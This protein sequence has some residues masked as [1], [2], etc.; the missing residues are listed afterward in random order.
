ML[1]EERME[2]RQP[3]VLGFRLTVSLVMVAAVI[4]MALTT[5]GIVIVIGAGAARQ[6]ATTLF[7][8]VG[9]AVGDQLE[10]LLAVPLAHLEYAATEPDA[11]ARFEGSGVFHPFFPFL[12]GALRSSPSLRSLTLADDQGLLQVIRGTDPEVAAHYRAPQGTRFIVRIASAAGQT[13]S[14]IHNGRDIIEQ[15]WEP[16]SIAVTNREWFRLARAARGIGSSDG[17]AAEAPNKP[18]FTLARAYRGGR[19]LS[20]EIGWEKLQ[21][22]LAAQAT[23]GQARVRLE[24]RGG[25]IAESPGFEM[26]KDWPGQFQ[27][28]NTAGQSFR[29]LVTAPPEVFNRDFVMLELAVASAT[30]ILLLVL[31]PLTMVFTRRLTR[32]VEK[33]S[34][35][36]DRVWQMDFSGEAPTSSRIREFDQLAHGFG[37]M[38]LKLQSETKVLAEA[39]LKLKKIVETGIALSTEKDSN[40][41]C[42]KILDTA[43][44]LTDADGGTLYLLDGTERRLDFNIMLNDTLGTRMGGTSA[45][46]V[47]P[48]LKVKLYKDDGEE[49]HNNVASHAF[50]TG[51]TIN[52]ADAY[53]DDRFD[54][55]GTRAFDENNKYRSMSFLTVPLKPMGGDVLGALQLIN[56]KG[57][58]GA[59]VP[60]TDD[61]QDFVEAL[62]AS[63]A[64]AI[65]NKQLLDDLEQLFDAIIDIINGAIGRKSPYT[66]GHCERVPIIATALA[67]ATSDVRSGPLAGFRLNT[68]ELRE[69]VLAAKLHDV[70]KVTTPEYVVDKS[71]KLETIYNRIHEIRTRFEV[72][73]RDAVIARHEAVMSK[74]KTAAAAD[75]ELAAFKAVLDEEWAFIAT[76][77]LGGEF[78]DPA[79][80]EKVKAIG[81]RT[82]LRYF[83]DR[84]GLS[85]EEEFRLAQV[86][87][88]GKAKPV[89]P[90]EE[91]LLADKTIH[92]IARQV[93]FADAYKMPDGEPYPFKTP[94]PEAL[95]NQGEIYNLIVSRGTLTNEEHFKIKEH[96]MQ[97]I[98]MLDRLPWP[99]GLERVPTI[100]G[101]HH[102]TLIGT[103]YPFQRDARELSMQSRILTVADIFEALTASDR[104]Y[105]KPKMLSEAVKVLYFFKKDQHIDADLFDLFLT[106]GVYLDYAKKYLRPDQ[107]DEVDIQPYLGPVPPSSK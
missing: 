7:T 2:T 97:S 55:S 61:M 71:T 90:A 86:E 37:Q 51:E 92:V 48:G 62:A 49:N 9:A 58:D 45:T 85:W 41:L 101:E 103:G 8:R 33:L 93:A 4:V 70:G 43:K 102:E 15:R 5:V 1:K 47:P 39:Q 67:K 107:I 34:A 36:V 57:P 76:I 44:E 73:Y 56:A 19:V 65:Y 50:L 26:H 88:I 59:N 29:I 74:K 6:N 79:K 25:T 18:I 75:K 72:L 106:S 16:V 77:N 35:D 89:L 98:Y 64:T 78:L 23:W 81:A 54:F 94:V 3:A 95:Y 27:I 38:K 96:V 46:P 42:Q 53:D 21:A 31:V 30:A 66:G 24:D 87:G 52:I 91:H 11:Q 99:K 84:L 68:K 22:S 10:A 80:I 17:M 100:A 28:R 13:L 60:F 40:A 105:K 82:W 69:F 63:A 32:I 14:F 104:P 83:D 12:E 20:V